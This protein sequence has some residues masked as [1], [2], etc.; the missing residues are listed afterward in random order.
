MCSNYALLVWDNF[1]IVFHSKEI[2]RQLASLSYPVSRFTAFRRAFITPK[3]MTSIKTKFTSNISTLDNSLL[4]EKPTCFLV[5]DKWSILLKLVQNY[6]TQRRCLQ[7]V[8]IYHKCSCYTTRY[9]HQ[10]S[11]VHKKMSEGR[12]LKER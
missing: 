5:I 4:K 10:S 9:E 6:G 8:H 7:T 12:Q 1:W 11:H 2:V 3:Q